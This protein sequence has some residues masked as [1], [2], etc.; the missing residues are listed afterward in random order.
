M[1]SFDLLTYEKRGPL[2]LITMNRPKSLNA[3]NLEL[4]AQLERA[5]VEAQMD[6]TIQIVVL[7]GAGRAFCAGADLKSVADHHAGERER[8]E[9]AYDYAAAAD[10]L[11]R[12]M[13]QMGKIIIAMVNGIAHAGG[14]VLAACSDICVA[15]DKATFRIPEGL[16]GIADELST[17][18]LQASIGMA[19]TKMLILSAEEISAEEAR[20]MGLIAKVVPHEQ[21][22]QG[23]EEMAQKVLRTGPRARSIFKQLL[24]DR[25]PKTQM[26]HIVESHL[27]AESREGAEAFAQKRKANWIP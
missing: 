5:L 10:G 9:G 16:V 8:W 22:W 27:G 23:V 11:F 12:Q 3:L 17:T 14:T 21:L 1:K 20:Q 25:L 24:N 26:R 2:V 18:W 15:S 4:F 6:D 7:T 19:R 13:T